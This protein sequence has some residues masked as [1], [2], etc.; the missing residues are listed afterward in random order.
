[1]DMVFGMEQKVIHMSGSGSLVRQMV[2]GLIFGSTET[3]TRE[4]SS[5]A[6]SMVREKNNF[7]MVIATKETIIEANHTAM[8]NIIGETEHSTKADSHK[9]KEMVLEFGRLQLEIV[10]NMRENI[11]KIANKAMV[12]SLGTLATFTRVITKLMSAVDM[13]KC[14]GLTDRTTKENGRTDY[15]TVKVSFTHLNMV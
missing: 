4:T 5:K 6:S 8:A 12:Y 9:G 7:Q 11:Y 13:G 2:M 1:M 3:D 15:S 10:I 14:I